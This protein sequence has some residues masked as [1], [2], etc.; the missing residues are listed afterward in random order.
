[1][2]QFPEKGGQGFGV[3]KDRRNLLRSP[4]VDAVP[5]Q[6][7]S[8]L[9]VQLRN[10]GGESDSLTAPGEIGEQLATQ[11]TLS[12]CCEIDPEWSQT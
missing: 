9:D 7:P 6:Q 4:R 11:C 1:M 8:Q 5:L 12:L 3:S 10:H 2:L